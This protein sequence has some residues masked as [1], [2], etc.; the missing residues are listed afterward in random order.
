MRVIITR[1]TV[2]AGKPVFVDE[3]HDL[4]DAEARLL[5]RMDKAT[6]APAEAEAEVE[7]EDKAT[8]APAK[9]KGKGK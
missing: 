4:A 6:E 1:N 7:A 8:E 5:I 2:A 3:V 9:P